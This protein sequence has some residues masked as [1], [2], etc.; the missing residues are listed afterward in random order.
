MKLMYSPKGI[1]FIEF[2]NGSMLIFSSTLE[3]SQGF[4]WL[5]FSGISEKSINTKKR[6]GK[7]VKMSKKVNFATTTDL[8]GIPKDARK[9]GLTG[10]TLSFLKKSLKAVRDDDGYIP[11]ENLDTLLAIL[12]K[13]ETNDEDRM[14]DD[15]TA[16]ESFDDL[17]ETRKPRKLKRAKK[18]LIKIRRKK[19]KSKITKRK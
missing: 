13:T 15:P 17:P 10:I 16:T 9:A 2:E 4:K 12:E 7:K 1:P 3:K 14:D 8:T 5:V 11:R 18:P 6:G 19:I